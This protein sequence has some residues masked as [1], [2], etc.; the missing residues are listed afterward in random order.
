MKKL[1][2]IFLF[3]SSAFA[4]KAQNDVAGT[5]AVQMLKEFYIAYNTAWSTTHNGYV[6]IKKL[7]SLQEKYC[8]LSL[9]KEL[10]K[11]FKRVGLDHDEL[12]NDEFTDVAH[13]NTLRVTIDKNK[14]N[15]YIVY[16]TVFDKDASNKPIQIKIVIQVTVV[17][18]RGSFKIASVKG[19][20]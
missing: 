12:I 2:F 13:L 19:I 5:Q 8:T 6:L 11:E 16:Y 18:E 9:R 7:D 20:H 3:I 10:K 15:N 4:S 17:K 14:P 1:I